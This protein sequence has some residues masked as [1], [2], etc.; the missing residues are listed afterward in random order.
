MPSEMLSRIFS[1][2]SHLMIEKDHIYIYIYI[3]IRY[4][5]DFQFQFSIF[6]YSK[7]PYLVL[8]PSDIGQVNN[9]ILI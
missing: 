2:L 4:T 1:P 6:I 3:Y 5:S 9:Y 7:N 8:Q